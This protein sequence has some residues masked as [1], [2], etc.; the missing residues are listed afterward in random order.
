MTNYAR[1]SQNPLFWPGQGTFSD[2]S[3]VITTSSFGGG[4]GSISASTGKFIFGISVTSGG[5]SQIGIFTPGYFLNSTPFSGVALNQANQVFYY[6]GEIGSNQFTIS[7]SFAGVGYFCIDVGA[8]TLWI[9]I[10]GVNWYGAGG[11]V[12]TAS[13]VAAGTGGIN[14]GAFPYVSDGMAIFC[15]ANTGQQNFT[16]INTVAGLGFTPPSGFS[17]VPPTLTFTPSPFNISNLLGLSWAGNSLSGIGC[18]FDGGTVTAMGGGTTGSSGVATGSTISD[19]NIHTAAIQDTTFNTDYTGTSYFQAAPAGPIL[20]S[21]VDFSGSTTTE[22]WALASSAN[23]LSF[24]LNSNVLAHDGS[25]GEGDT[26]SFVNSSGTTLLTASIIYPGGGGVDGTLTVGT[27]T[28][29]VLTSGADSQTTGSLALSTSGGNI[30]GDI[31]FSANGT[32]YSSSSYT[33]ATGTTVDNV[34]A[35]HVT[36]VSTINGRTLRGASVSGT[37][38]TAGSTTA[39]ITFM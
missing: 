1:W 20:L 19:Y 11:T 14:W 23:T 38:A 34:T 26:F 18:S 30:V 5:N 24:A 28:P 7:G 3:Q 15:D 39:I 27:F 35:L 29:I 22:T 4:L 8:Q 12:Y 6:Q 17:I 10:D 9:S 2:D 16:L 33:F 31:Y 13:Q 32:N 37:G 36:R 21:D 25:F